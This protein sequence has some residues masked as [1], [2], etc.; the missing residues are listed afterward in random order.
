M[1]IFQYILIFLVTLNS[2]KPQE[3]E[4][5]ASSPTAIFIKPKAIIMRR[6]NPLKLLF[7][8]AHIPETSSY[9][10]EWNFPLLKTILLE[11]SYVT[12]EDKTLFIKEFINQVNDY[13]NWSN[14]KHYELER[15]TEKYFNIYK[16]PDEFL[17][18]NDC[19]ALTYGLMNEM[20]NDLQPNISER[21]RTEILERAAGRL[22]NSK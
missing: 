6:L 11:S 8:V 9:S 14:E 1:I 18:F 2:G 12:D 22:C 10:V 7:N 21:K 13:A 17:P 16:S 3:T 5:A 19:S 15:F 20:I 4:D